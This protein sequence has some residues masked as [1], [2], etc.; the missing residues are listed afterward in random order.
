M[1][2]KEVFVDSVKLRDYQNDILYA[3]EEEGYRKMVIILG[4]RAR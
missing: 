3:L 1:M 4:R 2:S